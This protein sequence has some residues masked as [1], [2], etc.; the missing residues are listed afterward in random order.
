[1]LQSFTLVPEQIASRSANSNP[2]NCVDLY[3]ALGF[4]GCLVRTDDLVIFTSK[5][6]DGDQ[7]IGRIAQIEDERDVDTKEMK[8]CGVHRKV[9]E[10]NGKERH[11]LV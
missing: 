2:G 4:S 6:A 11:A 8:D 5:L 9:Q 10:R 3:S 1:M 7:F